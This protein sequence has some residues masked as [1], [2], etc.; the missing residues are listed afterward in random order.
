[1]SVVVVNRQDLS[2][3]GSTIRVAK[4]LPGGQHARRDPRRE[5]SLDCGRYAI[6]DEWSE[7]RSVA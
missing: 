1:M 4:A 2:V 7:A 3:D 5:E 6:I